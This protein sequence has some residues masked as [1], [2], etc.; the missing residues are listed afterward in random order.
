M[1]NE[2]IANKLRSGDLSEITTYQAG[3]MQASAHRTLQK[4]CDDILKPYNISKMHWLIIGTALDGGT[5]GIRLTD[6][7]KTLNTTLPYITNAISLL[8]S[9]G[10]IVRVDN[11]TDSRSKLIHINE[12]F[13][14]KCY[15]IEAT[16]RQG[17]RNEIY[18][19]IDPAELRIYMKVMYQLSSGT[20]DASHK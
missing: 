4:I 7:A 2:S 18:K 3:V 20:A 15:E 9:K 1:T 13:V 17:L 10:I 16:L 5:Q 19:D 11:E 6:L 12:A 14:P 8:V